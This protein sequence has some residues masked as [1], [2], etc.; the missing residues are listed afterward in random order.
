MDLVECIYCVSLFIFFHIKGT[1][2]IVKFGM[3]NNVILS[4]RSAK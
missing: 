3:Q 1:S 2:R 4:I